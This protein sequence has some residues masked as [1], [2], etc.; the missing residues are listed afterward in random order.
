MTDT[1]NF[2]RLGQANFSGDVAALFKDQFIPELLT[3]FDA[4]RVM[5][6]YVRSKTITKGK[7]ASFPV[8]GQTFRWILNRK[9]RSYKRR[10]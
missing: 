5:K 9:W 8:L 10:Y 2:T 1:Y 3:A 7:S 4:K 6:N